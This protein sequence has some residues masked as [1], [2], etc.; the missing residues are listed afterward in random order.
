MIPSKVLVL[1]TASLMSAVEAVV[2]FSLTRC[3]LVFLAMME[4]TVVLPTPAGP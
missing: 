3:R 4:A 2:P 1:A